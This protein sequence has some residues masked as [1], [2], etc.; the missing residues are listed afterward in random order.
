MNGKLSQQPLIK[1]PNVYKMSVLP[2]LIYN[3][4]PIPTKNPNCFYIEI[5]ALILKFTWEHRGLR[6]TKTMWKKKKK[7]KKLEDSHFVILKTY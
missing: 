6:M 3:F 2:K 1:R 5:D 7:R 4:N